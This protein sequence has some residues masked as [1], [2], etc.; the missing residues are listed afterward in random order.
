MKLPAHNRYDYIPIHKRTQYEWP[1]GARLAVTFN[2][3]IEYFAF[4]AGLGSDSIG[5]LAAQGQR[6]YAG[7]I[8]ATAWASG[9]TGFERLA[10]AP[11]RAQCQF[12]RHRRHRDV[13]DHHPGGIAR[14]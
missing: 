5:T 3:N 4:G 6:N 14:Y 8:R 7:A 13:V 2:N 10:W 9:T 11:R 1:G 12:R